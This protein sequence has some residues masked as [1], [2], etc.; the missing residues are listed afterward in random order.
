VKLVVDANVLF[1]ALIK[2]SGTRRLFFEERLEIYAPEYLFEE[3]AEHREEIIQKAHRSEAEFWEV[4][5][6]LKSRI[7]VV[8]VSEFEKFMERAQKVSPDKDD[9]VY[10]AV[11][12]AV[13]G[14]IWSNDGNLKG[15]KAVQVLSTEEIVAGA[16]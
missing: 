9:A 14:A 3:F 7:S 4:M 12:F 16:D 15:Q 2:D 10:F 1:S 6:I 8:P 13:E 5:D 11:A